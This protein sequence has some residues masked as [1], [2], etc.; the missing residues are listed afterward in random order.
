MTRMSPRECRAALEINLDESL[1]DVLELRRILNEER[2]ALERKDS[3]SLHD[4][5]DRKGTCIGKMEGLEAR[6]ASIS[7]SCGFGTGP[8]AMTGLTAWCDDSG[9]IDRSW[10]EFMDVTRS[11]S[12][13]N[14]ANG[15]IIHVRRSQIDDALAILRG[16]MA[17]GDTYGPAGE[18]AGVLENRALAEA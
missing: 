1:N 7:K 2:T 3:I 16:G 18:R 4:L 11:C 15:A 17:N 8:A 14:A 10:M 13:L 9:A 6:R 5:A 12:D